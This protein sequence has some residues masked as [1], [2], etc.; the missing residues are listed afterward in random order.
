[1]LTNKALCYAGAGH[2]PLILWDNAAGETRELME[3]GLFLGFFP[4]AAYTSVEIPFRQGDWGVLYTDG[5]VEA[6]NL[7]EEQFGAGR[8]KLFLQSHHD[9]PAGQFVDGAS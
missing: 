3:N 4:D 5:I 9:L 8:F 1:M 7:A 6:T 2:P